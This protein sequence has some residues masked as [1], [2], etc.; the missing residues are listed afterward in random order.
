MKKTGS[1]GF[2]TPIRR[3]TKNITGNKVGGELSGGEVKINNSNRLTVNFK[4][5]ITINYIP[6][7]VVELF[8]NPISILAFGGY[9]YSEQNCKISLSG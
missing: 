7:T 9:F 5:K 2:K 4:K 6:E 8:N 3:I 1:F